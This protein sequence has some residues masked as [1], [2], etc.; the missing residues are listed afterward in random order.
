MALSH[1]GREVFY[2][3]YYDSLI[4]VV[5]VLSE[6]V[7]DTVKVSHETRRIGLSPSG[8]YI[9]SAGSEGIFVVYDRHASEEIEQVDVNDGIWDFL[10]H[11]DGSTAF[12]PGEKLTAVTLPQPLTTSETDLGGLVVDLEW[13]AGMGDLFALV[14][15]DDWAT[16][17]VV[18]PVSLEVIREYGPIPGESHRRILLNPRTGEL[19]VFLYQWVYSIDLGTGRFLKRLPNRSR[20]HM[21]FTPEYDCLYVAKRAALPID[22]GEPVPGGLTIRSGSEYTVESE[23]DFEGL[24]DPYGILMVTYPPTVPGDLDRD[25][26]VSFQDFLEFA[27]AYGSRR[28]SVTWNFRADFNW[29]GQVDFSD[30]LQFAAHFARAP[31]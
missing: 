5:D 4:Y 27:A 8:Q 10:V 22:W 30:F 29:D 19:L 26:R 21:A 6:R 3:T 9:Y 2:P 16:V 28:Q 23:F 15:F 18:D 1:D 13:H 24:W 20:H 7:V 14:L 12:F 11:P 25:G 17:Y 31:G